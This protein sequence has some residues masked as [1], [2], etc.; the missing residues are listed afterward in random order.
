MH[1]QNSLAVLNSARKAAN[2]YRSEWLLSLNDEMVTPADLLAEAGT[3]AGR[4]L[5][6]I[7]LSQVLLSQPGWGRKRCDFILKHVLS[8]A[9]VSIDQKNLT[10]GWLLDSR[11]G[12]RRYQAWLDAMESKEG[13]PWAGFP[14]VRN[15]H[16]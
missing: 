1:P 4:P 12:G 7:S 8:I 15:S 10:V 5:L 9:G 16:V 2:R 6:K 14:Y 11:A 13:P 3:A